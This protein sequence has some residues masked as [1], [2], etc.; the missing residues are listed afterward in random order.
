MKKIYHLSYQH[1]TGTK[2]VLQTDQLFEFYQRLSE[3][4]EDS[5]VSDSSIVFST[6]E[7]PLEGLKQAENTLVISDVDAARE[8]EFNLFKGNRK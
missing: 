2:G 8:R 6:E 7:V 1:I 3:L 5:Y 4:I